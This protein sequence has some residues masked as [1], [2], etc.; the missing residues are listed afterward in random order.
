MFSH[1]CV[2][3]MFSAYCVVATVHD[4]IKRKIN[5][6][7]QINTGRPM[8]KTHAELISLSRRFLFILST[9]TRPH[10]RNTILKTQTV[11]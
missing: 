5:M 4:K 9:Y 2:L 3:K 6:Y 10:V 7:G 8:A 1:Q 11:L